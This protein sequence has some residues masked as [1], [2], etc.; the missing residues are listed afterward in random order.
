[1]PGQKVLI[2]LVASDGAGQEGRSE[3]L[4]TVLPGRR[5]S[6]PLAAAVVEQ[7]GVLALDAKNLPRVFDLHDALTIAPEETIPNLS[8]SAVAIGSRPARECPL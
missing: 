1:L 5:F 6:N 3:T 2:T 4:E 7:R 8:L